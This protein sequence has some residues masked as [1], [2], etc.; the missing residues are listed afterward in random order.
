VRLFNPIALRSQRGLGSL[1][2]F[3]RINRRMHNKSFTADN[4][5]TI[6][7]GRNI[8]D[9]YFSARPDVNF[10]DLDVLAIGPVVNQISTAFDLYWN[11]PH[12]YR[13]TTLAQDDAATTE[14]LAAA[15]AVI[16][17]ELD[18]S[19]HKA[20]V[21]ALQA[22]PADRALLEDKYLSFHWGRAVALYDS[23]DKV[24][25]KVEDSTSGVT[26]GLNEAFAHAREELIIVSPY[27]VPGKSGMAAFA[28]WRERG[29]AV[30]VLTNSLAATDVG[31]SHAGYAHHREDLLKL[32]VA[33]YELKPNPAP[34]PSRAEVKAASGVPGSSR[35]SLHAK[36]FIF[37]RQRVFIGSLNFTPRSVQL[38]TEI[39]ILFENQTLAHELAGELETMM[40]EDSYHLKRD[41][42]QLRWVTIEDGVERTFTGEPGVGVFT[43]LGI[44]LL[45]LLPIEGHL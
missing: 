15:R 25:T 11:G 13:I 39:G 44:F 18:S 33:L 23:P 37:D 20:Y 9:E 28:H 38:N 3:G 16:E 19:R 7:G 14:R 29:V 30:K 31:A 5:A 24:A 6:V 1:F 8:G 36:T 41:G 21:Q 22:S 27:F 12:S 40:Q 4:Q 43:R 34:R 26:T 10:G 42:R 17:G 45:S 35:A 2:E 32:G